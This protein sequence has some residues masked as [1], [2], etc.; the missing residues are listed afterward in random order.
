[1]SEVKEFKT[2]STYI[3]YYD[4]ND[5][6]VKVT[7]KDVICCKFCGVTLNISANSDVLM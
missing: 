3:I 1:M 6:V 2:E 5:T 7:K 4:E